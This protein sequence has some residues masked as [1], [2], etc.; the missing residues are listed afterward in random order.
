MNRREF[1][2]AI[3]KADSEDRRIAWFGALLTRES[4]LRGKLIIV[5]GSAIELYLSSGL[6]VSQDI[7]VVGRKDVIEPI[8]ER[9]GFSSEVGRDRR[10]YWT[11]TGLGQVDLVGV[12]D[13][14][15]LPPRP[16]PTPFGEVL[17][18][19]VEYLIV[20]RLM[21]AGREHSTEYFRQAEV[22]AAE[23]RRDLDWDYIRVLAG[24]EHVLPL[25]RQLRGQ[26]V[27]KPARVK[28]ARAAARAPAK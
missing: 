18:G 28:R 4:G 7:D 20:R 16:Q 9:W 27:L 2:Q 15:G 19:A 10:R 13:R 5:G 1:E 14:S 17:L 21:R 22:L 12:R 26:V 6:Y 25:Y 11:K 23:Y 3:A 8:L 24:H